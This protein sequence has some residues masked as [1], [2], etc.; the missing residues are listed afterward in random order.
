MITTNVVASYHF[1]GFV[2]GLIIFTSQHILQYGTLWLAKSEQVTM[3]ISAQKF[4]NSPAIST[5]TFDL[6]F[7][8]FN[9]II[10]GCMHMRQIAL[11]AK[12]SQHCDPNQQ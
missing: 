12:K 4:I 2:Y 6:R 8:N 7:F 11:I 10:A 5:P 1:Q 9:T 3:A